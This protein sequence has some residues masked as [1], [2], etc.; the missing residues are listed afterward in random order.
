[1]PL[2]ELVDKAM[3]ESTGNVC[4]NNSLVLTHE[5]WGMHVVV[6]VAYLTAP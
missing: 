1:M 3:V 5:L 2:K 6:A 4:F